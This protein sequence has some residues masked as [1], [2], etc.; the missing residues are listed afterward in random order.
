VLQLQAIRPVAI[1]WSYCAPSRAFDVDLLGLEVVTEHYRAEREASRPSNAA[2]EDGSI[3]TWEVF[4]LIPLVT[5][6]Q[7]FTGGGLTE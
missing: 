3:D 2:G 7:R 4:T 6:V 5:A 1:V